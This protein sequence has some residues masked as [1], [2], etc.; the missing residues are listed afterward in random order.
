M[1]ENWQ[2]LQR[3]MSELLRV[4]QQILV[5]SKQKKDLLVAGKPADLEKVVSQEEALLRKAVKVDV[6][7]NQMIQILSKEF[8]TA[9]DSFTTI[10]ELLA[11]A[12]PDIVEE[13]SKTGQAFNAVLLELKQQNELNKQ[14]IEQ[15]LKI[16]NYNINL[17]S[18]QAAGP[19]YSPQDAEK[20][21]FHHRPTLDY[22]G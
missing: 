11:F 16:V 8:V 19:T 12:P 9:T 4:Y 15:A 2:Q 10:E 1:M 21:N 17:Y 22:H 18:S 14:L 5:L 6:A 7:R 20:N 13:L 3:L